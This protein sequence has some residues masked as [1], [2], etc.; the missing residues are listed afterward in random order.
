MKCVDQASPT[1]RFGGAA[2]TE[3]GRVP[4]QQRLQIRIRRLNCSLPQGG[5]ET[6]TEGW[7]LEWSIVT[8]MGSF[9]V[10]GRCL[11]WICEVEL[12][13]AAFGISCTSR[14]VAR[15]QTRTIACAVQIVF[16]AGFEM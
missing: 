6:N 4:C 16:V 7:R 15:L 14:G 10:A 8:T 5:D 11:L 12:E 9:R 1:S 2:T 13:L 3:V